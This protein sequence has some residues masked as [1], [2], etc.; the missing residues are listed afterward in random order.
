M[1]QTAALSHKLTSLW[2]KATVSNIQVFQSCNT[3]I[4]VKKC[5]HL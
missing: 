5:E 1:L 2:L 3:N 4:Q